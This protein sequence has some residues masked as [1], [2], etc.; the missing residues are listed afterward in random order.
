MKNDSCFQWGDTGD[1]SGIRVGTQFHG[2]HGRKV[3]MEHEAGS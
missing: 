2:Q 1:S 3:I